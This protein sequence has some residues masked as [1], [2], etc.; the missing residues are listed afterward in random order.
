VI[1]HLRLD[2]GGAG[3]VV[4]HSVGVLLGQGGGG[5]Q[6]SRTNHWAWGGE[7]VGGL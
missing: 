3:A 1:A 7:A 4:H 6:D 2:A 5:D